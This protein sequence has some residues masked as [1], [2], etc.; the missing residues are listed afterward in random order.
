V[1]EQV[2][3]TKSRDNDA[4]L[5]EMHAMVNAAVHIVASES[6]SQM[7]QSFGDLMHESWRLKKSLSPDVTNSAI[8]DAYA[9]ALKAGAY[10]GKI[11]GA[12][13]GGFLTLIVEPER[14]DSVRM[15]LGDLL[16]VNFKFEDE[17]SSIIYL[18]S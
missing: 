6:P 3:R 10:G 5:R 9:R 4:F 16:E 18:R 14:Q 13:G 12:G 11:S 1:K 15:A 8:D 17:G 7:L 2:A